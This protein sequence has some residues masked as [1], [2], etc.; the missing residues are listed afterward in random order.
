MHINVSSRVECAKCIDVYVAHVMTEDDRDW[1]SEAHS[2]YHTP[3]V[4]WRSPK[5]QAH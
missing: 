5:G 2:Q 4:Q 1:S 3:W